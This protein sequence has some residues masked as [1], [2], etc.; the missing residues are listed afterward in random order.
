MSPPPVPD[1]ALFDF[2]GVIIDSR[3]AVRSAINL[4][5]ADHGMGPRPPRTLDRF[6]GPPI[7]GAFA[8]LTG[9]DESS[10]TVA[11]LADTYHRR[12][13]DVYLELTSLED[14]IEPVLRALTLPTVLATAKQIEFVD[15]LLAQFGIS[16]CFEAV[17]A[18]TLNQ[19]H[20]SK[21]QTVARALQFLGARAPVL[22][23]DRSYDI[24]AARAN[25]IR[26]IGVTW[27]IGDRDELQRAGADVILSRPA[28]LQRLLGAS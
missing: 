18:P 23:G 10:S 11:E 1:A 6:I 12:Y 25:G 14:G 27:G 22:V 5:L 17:F 19:L 2:D 21:T 24:E 13:E 7:L 4:S 28:E 26:C 9:S 8:E 16:D 3:A 20:E 15:P